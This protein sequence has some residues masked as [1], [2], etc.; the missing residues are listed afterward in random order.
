V[1]GSLRLL[2]ENALTVILGGALLRFAAVLAQRLALRGIAG[3]RL[4]RLGLRRAGRVRRRLRRTAREARRAAALVARRGRSRFAI[5]LL[6][7]GIHWGARYSVIAALALFLGIPF[8][9][10]LFWLLQWVVFTFMS[11]V[12]TPG[13]TGGAELAFTAVYA[14]LLPPGV[15]GLATAAWRLFTFY[16]PVGLAAIFFTV[17]GTRGVAEPAP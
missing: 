17:L 11:F 13:A 12:P 10:V 1:A 16:V 4:R 5:T 9:P 7:T 6:L 15:I 3:S 8:D 14:T 2:S